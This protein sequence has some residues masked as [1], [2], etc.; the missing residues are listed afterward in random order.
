L[1]SF[2]TLGFDRVRMFE[3][4]TDGFALRGALGDPE[5]PASLVV[6]LTN[7]Y[8]R[9][10]LTKAKEQSGPI[11]YHPGEF[12][13][14]PDAERV[15]RPIDVQWLVLPLVSGGVLRGQ[16]VAD[17]AVSKRP[18]VRSHESM[19]V[20]SALAAQTLANTFEDEALNDDP[21]QIR[22]LVRLAVRESVAPLVNALTAFENTMKRAREIAAQMARNERS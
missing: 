10:T 21:E 11:V 8:V 17:N 19:S 15:G 7:P 16:L 1:R 5:L 9:N 3:L 4:T 20:F 14:D 22:P 2:K 18:I 13:P 6:P 12:G